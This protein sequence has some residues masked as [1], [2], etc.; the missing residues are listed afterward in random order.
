MMYKFDTCY[1]K[2]VCVILDYDEHFYHIYSPNICYTF[3]LCHI[4]AKYC[5]KP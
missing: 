1:V 2:Y 4:R 3:S 5:R